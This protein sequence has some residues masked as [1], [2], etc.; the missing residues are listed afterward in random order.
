MKK[1]LL[2]SAAAL[3]VLIGII[4][5]GGNSSSAPVQP[6]ATGNG[7]PVAPSGFDTSRPISAICPFAA[8]GGTDVLLR[9]LA[10]VIS[11]EYGITVV[12]ENVTG[13]SGA[14][15]LAAVLAKRPDGRTVGV[16]GPSV[17]ALFA[18][19]L[20]D[21][22]PED[23]TFL[24]QLFGYPSVI[25]TLKSGKY[26]TL[27]DLVKAA[28][29]DPGKVTIGHNATR[30]NADALTIFMSLA[31]GNK[32]LFGNLPYDGAARAV[33]ELL[34][35][36]I[37]AVIGSSTDLLVQRDQINMLA[38]LGKKSSLLPDVPSIYDLGYTEKQYPD[39]GYCRQ[40][41]VGPKG[42]DPA[43][44]QYLSQV[45]AGAMKTQELQNFAKN[46]AFELNPVVGEKAVLELW[47]ETLTATHNWVYLFE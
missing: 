34:G 22:K 6:A 40:Y 7:K 11:K 9:K 25:G 3:V 5:C 1:K 42:M 18:Q 26:N 17:Q 2:L 47:N 15:G 27:E 23:C 33:T 10:G 30:T 46:M 24:N 19:E 36:H 44:A 31:N 41:I 12:V 45:F 14:V 8:G 35:G 38:V 4:G 28:K 21:Y 16:I 20:F 39:V 29:S 32:D 13:G 43:I 37:D